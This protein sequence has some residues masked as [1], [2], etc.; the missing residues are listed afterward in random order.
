MSD[1]FISYKR[2]DIIP[3][4]ALALQLNSL[5]WTV[6]WDHDIPAG[7]DYDKVIESELGEA[8]CVLVLWS[9]RS[10]NSRNV[11]DEANVALD[12]GVLIPVLI[13]KNI[14]PP[15][16]FR[17]IQSVTWSYNTPTEKDDF[18]D[19]LRHAKRLIGDPP[20]NAESRLEKKGIVDEKQKEKTNQIKTKREKLF[21][22]FDRGIIS[23]EVYSTSVILLNK[24]SEPSDKEKKLIRN[25]EAFLNDGLSRETFVDNW[26]M[27]MQIPEKPSTPSIVNNSEIK[28]PLPE[29]KKFCINCGN[30]ITPGQSFCIKC[31]KRAN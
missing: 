11:K 24:T 5:G 10:V 13:S 1:I 15:L 14:L 18:K 26:E 19:L 25:L 20:K 28:N 21:D 17:M 27:I 2:E 31:G 16:G 9:E 3:A 30:L 29:K 12:R 4:K 22:L 23:V 8:K 7:E 6:W